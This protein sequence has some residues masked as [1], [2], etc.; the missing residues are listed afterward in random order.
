MAV[1]IF[2]IAVK[3]QSTLPRRERLPFGETGKGILNFN[4]R[5]REGS[6]NIR[7]ETVVST[8]NF[9]PRSREGSDCAM[10][11]IPFHRI[12]E[13]LFREPCFT[14][15]CHLT[16][17]RNSSLGAYGSRLQNHSPAGVIA[18]L[19]PHMDYFTLIMVPEV[20]EPQ[21]VTFF[22]DQLL[23]LPF[24]ES[25]LGLIYAAFK[26]GVLDPLAMGCAAF[27]HFSEPFPAGSGGGIYVVG[28]EQKHSITSIQKGDSHPDH[29]G[30]TVPEEVPVRRESGPRLFSPGEKDG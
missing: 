9:N 2:T 11:M 27:R 21:A 22:I 8:D 28:N 12:W 18:F 30:Y 4:P 7:G 15:C 25:R 6:D 19:R 3:F 5:S 10:K 17:S 14:G 23:Q 13:V 20:I 29:P 26:D 24:E 16:E 1:I